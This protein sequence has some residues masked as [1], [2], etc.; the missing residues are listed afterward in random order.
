LIGVGK[1]GKNLFSIGLQPPH[2]KP[3]HGKEGPSD[4]VSEGPL[5][6]TTITQDPHSKK[7]L[8]TTYS[9]PEDGDDSQKGD[10]ND[11]DAASPATLP[12]GVDF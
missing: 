3:L 9:V 12:E 2:Q 1:E 5:F 7:P 8:I 4:K 6:R 11:D 10:N